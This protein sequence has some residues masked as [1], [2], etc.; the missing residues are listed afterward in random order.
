[1][2]R[3]LIAA[4]LILLALLSSVLLVPVLLKGRVIGAILTQANAQL[5]ATVSLADADL[6]LLASFPELTVTLQGLKVENKGDFAG[7]T[8]AEVETLTLRT[9]VMSAIRGEDLE[10]LD[11][12]LTR[13]TLDVRV[14]AA[15]DSNWDIFPE[16]EDSADDSGGFTLSLQGYGIQGGRLS[17]LDEAGGTRVSP[18]GPGA[19]GARRLHPGRGG[20]GHPDPHGHPERGERRRGAAARGQARLHPRAPLPPG[21]RRHRALGEFDRDQRALLEPARAGR[22]GHRRLGAGPQA[23]RPGLGL[24]GAALPGARGVLGQLRGPGQRRPLHPVRPDPGALARR[25]R[26]PARLQAGPGH[27]GRQLPRPLPALRGH[28]HPAPGQPGAPGGGGLDAMV[29][30]VPKLRMTVQ[31]SP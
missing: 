1:M 27:H 12:Q 6:S 11:L 21:H 18:D 25:G 9:D 5:D 26:G 19:H 2:R 15:G 3:A 8:L 24:Q 14:N 17:Y 10:L 30:D 28:R 7:T 31:D 29:I 16:S 4:A 22:A 23:R 13:P 20:P